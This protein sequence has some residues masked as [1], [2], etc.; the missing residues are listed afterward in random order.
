MAEPVRFL[1]AFAQSIATM[2]LYGT[3][4]PARTRTIDGAYRVLRDL[5][6]H[7]PKPEFS[8]L[9]DEVVYGHLPLRE[10]RDWEWA[11]RLASAGVQRL[12]FPANVSREDFERFLDEVLARLSVAAA[13][14]AEMRPGTGATSIRFGALGIRG[15]GRLAPLVPVALAPSGGAGR[16]EL[17]DEVATV[18]WMHEEVSARGQ[19]PLLEAE[20]VVRSLAVAMH[21]DQEMLLPLLSLREFDEYTTTHSLNVSVLTMALSEAMGMGA[22]DVRA[23]GV[24]G[25]LHDLG[26]TRIPLEILNKPGK[27]TDEERGMMQA[28]TV[29]GAKL[30]LASDRELDLA[31]AVA[32]EHHIMI[33]GGGYPHRKIDRKCHCASTLVHVCDVYD[34]LRTHRP[35]R[36]AWEQNAVLAY[37][38]ERSG[39]DFDAET[40][41]VF[42]DLMR[43][44]EGRIEHSTLAELRAGV[45]AEAPAASP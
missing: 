36:A 17:S 24:A 8:F 27:L 41:Q 37:I 13:D 10:M 19:L 6:V 26:K 1:T 44:M 12:E 7:D 34:A 42:V 29:E 25:L 33:D 11:A 43:R 28:H 3:T 30:I 40:A 38:E 2:S 35:Y 39:T 16:Y 32:Y 15:E 23:F 22:R 45:Q 4:H 31:A 5:Q 9:G 21:G 14:S 18:E 20:S